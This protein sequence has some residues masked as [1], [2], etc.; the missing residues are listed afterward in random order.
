[1]IYDVAF[2]LAGLSIAAA[3]AFS[4]WGVVVLWREHHGDDGP[5]EKHTVSHNHVRRVR[6]KAYHAV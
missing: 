6:P 2:T 5:R 4:I 1:M 3:G